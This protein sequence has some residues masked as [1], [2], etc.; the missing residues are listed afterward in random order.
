LYLVEYY[1]GQG[2]TLQGISD[3]KNMDNALV[4]KYN[5]W[6]KRGKVPNDK[7]YAV[8]LPY[9]QY[10]AA[11]ASTDD[12]INRRQTPSAKRQAQS[13]RQYRTNPA[14]Y[15]V[16]QDYNNRK[17]G[18]KIN[19]IKGVHLKQDM[20]LETLE[21]ATG[22]SIKRLLYYNDISG[23][24]QP[25]AGELWYLKP[26]RSR[27]Q[28]EYHVLLEGEN[29]WSVS[30]K[31]GI[32]LSQL[33]KKNRTSKRQVTVKVGRVLWLQNTRPAGV[34]VAYQPVDA[35]VVANISGVNTL[36]DSN[37]Q[38]EKKQTNELENFPN[39]SDKPV[40]REPVLEPQQHEVLKSVKESEPE[41]LTKPQQKVHVVYSGETLYSISK[42]YGISI[43]DLKIWNNLIDSSVLSIG[44]QLHVYQVKLLQ[45]DPTAPLEDGDTQ[46][47]LHKV[48]PGETLYQIARDNH[49]T[50]KQ[51]MEWNE[52][53]DFN[54]QIGEE[55][56]IGK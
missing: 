2:K 16:V 5:K 37:R 36:P 56:R 3:Q 7:L 6:L 42:I 18:I 19:R 10:P 35:L 4:Q 9:D 8:I 12:N 11:L 22:V 48:K 40:D 24:K 54:L 41:K 28:E 45:D 53:T 13:A 43:N 46:F 17:K 26:K 32:K 47:M 55:L 21:R 29:L 34:P 30:Q 23:K 39:Q 31:Y 1:E 51:L 49:A 27:A 25:S 50:I 44:Q 52:K 14:K 15:P 33:R 38:P 20:D